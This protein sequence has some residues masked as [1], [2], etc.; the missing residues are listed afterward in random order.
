VQ[1]RGTSVSTAPLDDRA[2]QLLRTF[3][4]CQPIHL[5]AAGQEGGADGAGIW[6]PHGCLLSAT[7]GCNSIGR[8]RAPTRP[9]GKSGSPVSWFLSWRPARLPWDTQRPA[10]AMDHISIPTQRGIYIC[11]LLRS[12]L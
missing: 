2:A 8:C 12:L 5:A 9:L 10:R 11:D 4:H 1:T 6:L 7:D 3:P